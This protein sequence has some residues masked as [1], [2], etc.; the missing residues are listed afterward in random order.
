MRGHLPF[1]FQS[2]LLFPQ[3]R[4][5]RETPTPPSRPQPPARRA[6]PLPVASSAPGAWGT[7]AA[8]AFVPL[9]P[10]RLPS[11]LVLEVLPRGGRCQRGPPVSGG[12]VSPEGPLLRCLPGRRAVDPGAASNGGLRWL[13]PLGN[14]RAGS[15]ETLPAILLCVCPAVGSPGTDGGGVGERQARR[16]RGTGRDGQT[17]VAASA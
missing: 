5:P 3:G 1:H 13:L 6:L 2:F 8:A 9:R 7:Q 10:A 12:V 11:R 15:F 4:C 14:G 16:R 17:T